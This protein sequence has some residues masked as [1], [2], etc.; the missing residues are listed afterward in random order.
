L[1]LD[2]AAFRELEAFAQLGTELDPATQKRLDRGYRMVGL[3]KQPQYK[4][5]HVVDQILGIYAGTQGYL[6]DIPVDQVQAW[7][8]RYLEFM[9]S[10]HKDL[11]TEI[12]R[13]KQLDDR[14]I[15]RIQAA[16]AEFRKLSPATAA[17]RETVT[18]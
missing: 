1:R 7:E 16:L 3:L 13:T 4:P 15:E 9:H 11:W 18:V 12:D 5:M 6:D 17:A 8:A 10:R 2:L 14:Q